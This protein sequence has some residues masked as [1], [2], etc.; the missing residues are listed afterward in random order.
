MTVFLRHL[1]GWIVSAFSSREDLSRKPRS[2]SATV[3]FARRPTS[4]STH[5]V[6]LAVLGR[7]EKAVVRLDEASR[8][9]HS[10][11][12]PLLSFT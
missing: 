6:A 1:L 3:C 4:P 11:T 5:R 8:L 12:C 2:P 9:G 10:G 7:V